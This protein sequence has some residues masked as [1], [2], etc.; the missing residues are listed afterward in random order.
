[1]KSMDDKELYSLIEQFVD[2]EI[3]RQKGQER[4][5]PS[6]VPNEVARYGF[7]RGY[8]IENSFE[9]T[10]GDYTHLCKIGLEDLCV[11]T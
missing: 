3:E 6:D 9:P 1:M 10:V 2:A 8:L 7:I 5:Y 4:K 11:W